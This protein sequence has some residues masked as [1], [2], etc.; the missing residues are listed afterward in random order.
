MPGHNN[1]LSFCHKILDNLVINFNLIYVCFMVSIKFF[2]GQPF[3]RKQ[4]SNLD[5]NFYYRGEILNSVEILSSF[6]KTEVL[7]LKVCY[8]F[9]FTLHG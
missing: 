8:V 1:C 2:V 7:R 5:N 6:S 4:N 3:Y 9:A